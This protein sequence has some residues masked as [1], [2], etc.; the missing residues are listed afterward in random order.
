MLPRIRPSS[1]NKRPGDDVS[2]KPQR[3]LGG[4]FLLLVLIVAS[5]GYWAWQRYTGFAYHPMPG[6]EAGTSLVVESGDSLPVVL[7]KL[8][9]AGID[10]G[11]S[12]EWRVLARQ[13]HACPHQFGSDAMTAMRRNHI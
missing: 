10:T 2:R 13:L 11:E 4:F 1:S 12:L 3:R 6:I 9:A 5:A 8:R 7:R